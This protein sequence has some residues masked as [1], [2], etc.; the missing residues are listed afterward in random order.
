LLDLIISGGD[1][2][3]PLGVGRWDVGVKQGRIAIVGLENRSSEAARVI[4]AAGKIMV[5][6]GIE[7]HAH[8]SN[9]VTMQ[10]GTRD[11][12]LG[13]EEDT[14][15]M[16]FG[17]TTTHLDFCFVH[18]RTDIPSAIEQRSK[19]WAGKSHVDYNFHVALGGALP[20]RIFDQMREAIAEGF[21]SFKVFTNGTLPP[22]PQRLPFKLDFG[23][24]ETCPGSR[25]AKRRDHGGARRG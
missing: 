14:I 17:G 8:L 20:L 7:P 10:P 13:P 11:F 21:P 4:D 12:T 1:V 9:L 24:I 15:G 19:R 16:A 2:V 3:T 23:R 22:H 6:G 18:P 5:P 25:V